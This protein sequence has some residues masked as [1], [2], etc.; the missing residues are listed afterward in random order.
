MAM[1]VEQIIFEEG[2]FFR[3]LRWNGSVDEVEVVEKKD[4]FAPYR[5][6]SR[7][8]ERLALS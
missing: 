2:E 4:A 6:I 5:A 3:V 1:N 7:Q 8:G